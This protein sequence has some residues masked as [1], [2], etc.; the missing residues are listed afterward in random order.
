[1]ADTKKAQS[2]SMDIALA[3]II[4]IG[5]FFVFYSL[6]GT[7]TDTKAG[8]LK[9]EAYV[10]IKQITNEDSLVKV[11]EGNEVS[12]SKLNDLKNMDYDELKKRLKVS[13]D[14][15]IYIEDE[16]G[17]LVVINNSFKGIGAPT[18]GLDGTPCS[19]K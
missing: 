11:V 18:I 9:E 12:V 4:F 17:N 16:K 10:V 14:F 13:G 5:A 7:N 8:N 1:M 3:A 19:Q 2:W 15:C 6:L